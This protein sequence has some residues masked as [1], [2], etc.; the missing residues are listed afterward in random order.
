MKISRFDILLSDYV[1]TGNF[2]FLQRMKTEYP[3]ETKIL[4]ENV[5]HLG[6]VNDVAVSQ[7]MRAY[8]SDPTLSK[9]MKDVSAKFKDLSK[10]EKQLS[11]A[12]STLRK[13]CPKVRKPRVYSF[14]SA[15]NQSIVV[16]DTLVGISLDKYLGDDYSLYKKYYLDY[17][18]QTMKPSRIV[19]DF[20]Y[21]YLGSEYPDPQKEKRTLLY[22]MIKAGKINWVIS[23]ITDTSINK[24][25]GLTDKSEQ[26]WQENGKAVWQGLNK[27]NGKLLNTTDSATI[28]SAMLV[29]PNAAP[30]IKNKFEGC[31]VIIGTYIIKEYMS[32]HS[33]FTICNL[34]HT[35]DYS[36]LLK[37]SGYEQ[38]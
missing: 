21:F 37:E 38:N 9:L 23:K 29:V 16:S 3:I 31:G 14:V 20:L 24:T 33:N 2:S 22:E 4:I 6:G 18:R 19:P 1:E 26:W 36:R 17:Q 10:Y 15:L 11:E 27:N 12:F 35:N 34:L 28:H 32:R 8:Y 13:A 30:E 7:K 5:L 25:L